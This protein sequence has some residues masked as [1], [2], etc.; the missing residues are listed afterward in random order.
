DESQVRVS[1]R[2]LV[3][4]CA[5]WW[6][7]GAGHGNPGM[8]LAVA[9]AAGRYGHVIFPG[10]IHAPALEV[11]ERLVEGPGKG[12]ASRV[13]FTDNGSTATE[14]GIKMGFRR[15][16]PPRRE[17]GRSRNAAEKER[18]GDRFGLSEPPS[19]TRLSVV[20]QEGCYHGDTLGAMNV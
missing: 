3:D 13:F 19:G 4:A 14:V 10:N 17:A 7:Q 2:A 11:A 6:T 16:Y 20:A 18:E 1:H 8:A 9:E 15:V 12:W 5:S